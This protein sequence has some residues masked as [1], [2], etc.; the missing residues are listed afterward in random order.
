[1][2]IKM[3]KI[4]NELCIK[5]NSQLPLNCNY[6]YEVLQLSDINLE[7]ITSAYYLSKFYNENYC[8]NKDFMH[9]PT[10][11][12]MIENIIKYP[13]IIARE[14]N[15][16]EILGSSILKYFDSHYDID[17]YFPEKNTRYFS[18]TGILTNRR[19]KE[20]KYYGIG[21]KIYQ[22]MLEGVLKYKEQYDNNIRLMCVIDCRNNNS[23]NALQTATDNL[24]KKYNDK[25]MESLIVGYY[26]VESFQTGLLVEAPTFVIEMKMN[27]SNNKKYETVSL[28]Y[29]NNNNTKEESYF[30]MKKH[31]DKLFLNNPNNTIENID[32]SCGLVKYNPLLT[33]NYS[34]E[35]IKIDSN[36]T[37]IGNNRIPISDKEHNINITKYICKLIKEDLLNTHDNISKTLVRKYI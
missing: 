31:I 19:N 3:I 27:Q 1:M 35:N 26:E 33:Y 13:I 20:K 18:V 29:D 15:T 7:T 34:L 16:N 23:I 6:E 32:Y 11:E 36:G 24:N 9:I 5:E 8:G 10:F 22:I 12:Q 2:N 30:K 21:K 17:P 25:K 14:K 28:K 37:D 4:L